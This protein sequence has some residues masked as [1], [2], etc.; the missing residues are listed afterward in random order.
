[1][2]LTTVGE[3]LTDSEALMN[4][5]KPEREKSYKLG[6]LARRKTRLADAHVTRAKVRRSL[7][8]KLTA[9]EQLIL[10]QARQREEAAHG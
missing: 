8:L 3:D 4:I 7:D 2:D 9:D 1:M 5:T 10:E 6:M